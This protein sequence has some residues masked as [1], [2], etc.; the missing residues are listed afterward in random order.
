MSTS[1]KCMLTKYHLNKYSQDG[2]TQTLYREVLEKKKKLAR[3]NG[4][5]EIEQKERHLV[6]NELCRGQT[7]RAGLGYKVNQKLIK[8]PHEHRKALTSLVNDVDE[9]TTCMLVHLY[10]CA[11]QG[12][13]TTW[14]NVMQVDTS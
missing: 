7:D 10:S 11:A 8:D 13:W 4:V 1:V 5:K 14:F 6:I 2:T 3:W 12:N 9:E